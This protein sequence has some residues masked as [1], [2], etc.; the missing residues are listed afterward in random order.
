MA[1]IASLLVLGVSIT[2]VGAWPLA[3]TAGSVE[4]VLIP[5]R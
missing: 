5:C 3:L 2:L 4:K 1:A